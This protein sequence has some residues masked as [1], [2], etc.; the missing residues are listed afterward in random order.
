MADAGVSAVDEEDGVSL[1]LQIAY[2]R[3]LRD[4]PVASSHNF[5]SILRHYATIQ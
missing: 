5:F 4:E 1:F 3:R 2:L